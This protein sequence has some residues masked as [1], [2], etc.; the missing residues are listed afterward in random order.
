MN[1]DQVRFGLEL[2]KADEARLAAA[3]PCTEP[4]PD[5]TS[6]A[7]VAAVSSMPLTNIAAIKVENDRNDS[8]VI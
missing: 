2:M 1:A 7:D 3:W 8:E 4:A 5:Q 6:G